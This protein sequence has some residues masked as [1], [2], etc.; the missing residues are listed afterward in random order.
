MSNKEHA[1][2]ELQ[3]PELV[4]QRNSLGQGKTRH[5]VRCQLDEAHSLTVVGRVY[6]DQE[7]G[8][9]SFRVDF[10]ERFPQLKEVTIIR[11]ED[12]SI[13]YL[14]DQSMQPPCL[15]GRGRYLEAAPK[16][17]ATQAPSPANAT[18]TQS[19]ATQSAT[20]P[21]ETATTQG[22]AA[23]SA[24]PQSA[25]AA[26][27]MAAILGR[28]WIKLDALRFS[29]EDKI[30]LMALAQEYVKADMDDAA[31]WKL[32]SE[33]PLS[34]LFWSHLDQHARALCADL[35]HLVGTEQPSP[36]AASEVAPDATPEAAPDLNAPSAAAPAEPKV[37]Q[38]AT[39]AD[40]DHD[41]KLMEVLARF[42]QQ[43]DKLGFSPEDK[44]KLLVLGQE[45]CYADMSDDAIWSLLSEGPLSDLFMAQVDKQFEPPLNATTKPDPQLEEVLKRVEKQID[46][47]YFAPED[48]AKLMDLAH[49]RCHADMSDDD[50]WDLLSKG[51]LAD[52]Y[53]AQIDKRFEA[54]S[55]EIFGLDKDE[56]DAV[57]PTHAP[58][59]QAR[60]ET[61]KPQSTAPNAA[62]K[63]TDAASAASTE[64]L[65]PS[66]SKGKP[67]F[68]LVEP[69]TKQPNQ[70]EVT[71]KAIAALEQR[72]EA[73]RQKLLQHG[74]KI[75][76]FLNGYE[77]DSDPAEQAKYYAAEIKKRPTITRNSTHIFTLD[78]EDFSDV[79]EEMA[80]CGEP[81]QAEGEVGVP[82]R[83][84]FLV[85]R[86]T[87]KLLYMA[88]CEHSMLEPQAF[89]AE[90]Q[91]VTNFIA[92]A[93]G[94]SGAN[95]DRIKPLI[96]Y[97]KIFHNLD[98]LQTIVDAGF[99]SVMRFHFATDIAH[100]ATDYAIS[101]GMLKGKSTLK[102]EKYSGMLDILL[103][104]KL[105]PTLKT[106]QGE[107]KLQ[108]HVFLLPSF[109]E[110]DQEEQIMNASVEFPGDFDELSNKERFEL[111]KEAFRRAAMVIGSTVPTL[112]GQDVLDAYYE[113]DA[114]REELDELEH[115]D[116]A[117]IC[118]GRERS[119]FMGRIFGFQQTSQ[120]MNE[121][122]FMN[123]M[124]PFFGI[125][126]QAMNKLT[127]DFQ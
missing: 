68:T 99:D 61:V 96:T 3:L 57:E 103:P 9:I 8:P 43:I 101:Q 45:R 94:V 10:V 86:S 49:E 72:A 116:L 53:L 119:T 98:A 122:P 32:F 29:H 111:Q 4:I 21:T 79:P 28:I 105:C 84:V 69:E 16:P 15:D 14:K 39:A 93:R 60:T 118:F 115:L 88:P 89:I 126:N 106:A 17:Q 85:E 82:K 117:N 50:I 5:Q 30:K 23:S 125:L 20:A 76:M 114:K 62:G 64:S 63:S 110:Y 34:K 97:G 59:A 71:A 107:K 73:S 46:H 90:A 11:K 6:Q 109:L 77:R 112:K 78:V 19:A 24:A 38:R 35:F 83:L 66:A 113:S 100:A 67:T 87:C 81:L 51:P 7:F 92:K 31:L 121:L 75:G 1:L 48:K 54:I 40:T 44:A 127:P 124:A 42:E 41:Q 22:S 58:Q 80:L 36:A 18:A 108:L 56:D 55:N 27:N 26:P 65:K 52:M 25:A 120:L 70:D 95:V 12:G 47:L 13:V 123:Q 102:I 33:G 37:E 104:P 2:A 74:N 91:K